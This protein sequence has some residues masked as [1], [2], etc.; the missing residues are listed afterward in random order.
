MTIDPDAVAAVL[1]VAG[2]LLATWGI[3][4]ADKWRTPDIARR[5]APMILVGVVVALASFLIASAGRH[6]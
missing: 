6:Q 2:D 1:L 5:G 3:L 4:V